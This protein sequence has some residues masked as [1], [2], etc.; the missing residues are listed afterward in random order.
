MK[1]K[2]LELKLRINGVM[3]TVK[4]P[5]GLK[6]AHGVGIDGRTKVQSLQIGQSPE[7]PGMLFVQDAH[8]NNSVT[9]ADEL[10]VATQHAAPGH[11]IS[12]IKQN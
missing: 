3:T 1:T 10:Y 8:G 6:P 11:K 12:A 4:L 5:N 9:T 7:H 2:Q